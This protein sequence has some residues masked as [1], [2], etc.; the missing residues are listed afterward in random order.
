LPY[1]SLKSR[2]SPRI[3][4]DRSKPSRLGVLLSTE[5]GEAANAMIAFIADEAGGSDVP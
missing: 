1:V 2:L 4:Q 5:R 3:E